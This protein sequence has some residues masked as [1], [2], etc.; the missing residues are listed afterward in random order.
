M[1]SGGVGPSASE[2][3]PIQTDNNGSS[4]NNFNN[5]SAMTTSN[6]V[7]STSTAAFPLQLRRNSTLA[8]GAESINGPPSMATNSS[9][10]E[11]EATN[12]TNMFGQSTTSGAG[13]AGTGGGVFSS[14]GFTV[15]SPNRFQSRYRQMQTSRSSLLQQRQAE[16]QQV[17]V[18]F[19]IIQA[20]L[21]EEGIGEKELEATDTLLSS[22][23]WHGMDMSF[24][25]V[26]APVKNLHLDLEAVLQLLDRIWG[27]RET[28]LTYSRLRN[29]FLQWLDKETGNPTAGKVLG[30]NM[31]WVCLRNIQHPDCYVFIHA[32][33]GFIPEDVALTWRK[34]IRHL[35]RTCENNTNYTLE[36]E[37][38]IHVN[39]LFEA[40]RGF[41]PEKSIEHMLQLRFCFY[42]ASG[43][44]ENASWP[45]LMKEDSTFV[46][47]IKRQ[48]IREIEEFT[49]LV[50][51]RLR[52]AVEPTK[53]DHIQVKK[54]S[55][56]LQA[57]D[58]ALPDYV[59]RKMTAEACLKTIRD[60][61]I[62]DDTL[63]VVLNTVLSRFRSV[64]LL[65]RASIPNAESWK[66]GAVGEGSDEL[67]ESPSSKRKRL[68]EQS[69]S[70]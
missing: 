15:Y 49:L 50:V 68:M 53:P 59:V 5:G 62:A 26:A 45:E 25:G 35:R 18:E 19:P 70:Y 65:R 54:V 57:C 67:V 29:F 47:Y 10:P 38:L 9:I 46:Q 30:V 56:V 32:L 12:H 13:A 43:G 21:R 8:G 36:K 44:T 27:E 34:G 7:S 63:L 28:K 31:M 64:V 37:Q 51:E 48:M 33:K 41:F 17:Q 61:A 2:G 40:L 60:V 1:T 55:Q 23:H 52:A 16:L 66:A 39:I 3:S 22:G 69:P 24:L 4:N 20:W 6:S 42:R 14:S 58:P 11:L